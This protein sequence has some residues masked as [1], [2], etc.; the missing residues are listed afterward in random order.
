MSNNSSSKSGKTIT[1]INR[2]EAKDRRTTHWDLDMLSWEELE[3][4]M[5]QSD[6]DSSD[7][8]GNG[9]S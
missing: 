5:G 7:A 6:T 1:R 8:R 4:A 3:Q 2:E 9:G